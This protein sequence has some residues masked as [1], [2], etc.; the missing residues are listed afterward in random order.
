[1]IG[2]Y[3]VL[4]VLIGLP[5][6]GTRIANGK[7]SQNEFYRTDYNLWQVI[8]MVFGWPVWWVIGVAFFL[9]WFYRCLKTDVTDVE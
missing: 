6:A 9:M 5:I 7:I 1:M 8:S 4:C 3:L 2:I